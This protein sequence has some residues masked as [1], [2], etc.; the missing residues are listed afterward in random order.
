MKTLEQC[1]KTFLIISVSLLIPGCQNEV[2]EIDEDVVEFEMSFLSEDSGSLLKSTPTSGIEKVAS[3]IIT[4]KTSTG[5]S[6]GYT[7]SEL[8]IQQLNGTFIS[9]KILLKRGSYNLTEFM[10][11]DSS[12][13]ITYAAP[14]SGTTLGTLVDNPLPIGFYVEKNKSKKILVEV[15]NTNDKIPEDFGIAS[16]YMI[17]PTV[18]KF[19]VA[20]VDYESGKFLA[21]TIQATNIDWDSDVSS[22]QESPG[23]GKDVYKR[24]IHTKAIANNLIVL[25]DTYPTYTIKVTKDGYTGFSYTYSKDSLLHYAL[26]GGESPLKIEIATTVIGSITDIDGNIYKTVKIGSQIWMQENLLV[27]RYNDGSAIDI[28]DVTF[29]DEPYQPHDIV[30]FYSH[31]IIMNSEKLCPKGWHVPTI[32]EWNILFEFLGGPG[33]AGGKLKGGPYWE[34]D[35]DIF[36]MSNYFSELYKMDNLSNFT[37]NPLS[38]NIGILGGGYDISFWALNADKTGVA[39]IFLSADSYAAVIRDGNGQCLR[40]IKD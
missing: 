5:S 27:T 17:S 34:C 11:A 28:S 9:E 16:F 18:M 22:Y 14:A 4:I 37:A 26:P 38:I 25:D 32:D 10:L 21:A 7:S 13:N 36:W 1:I 6:T 3:I 2:S 29:E 40:C 20:I 24:I 31:N 39:N 8:K 33:I 19:P 30:A 15:I 12:G 35:D 23:A